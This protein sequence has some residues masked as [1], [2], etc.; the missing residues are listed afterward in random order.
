MRI[1]K[2]KMQIYNDSKGLYVDSLREV[3]TRRLRQRIDHLGANQKEMA[4][5]L[6]TTPSTIQ[7]W[8]KGENWPSSEVICQLADLLNVTP[9]WL[10]GGTLESLTQENVV[11][12]Q[13]LQ[14][15][16]DWPR[17]QPWDVLISTA[18]ALAEFKESKSED[19]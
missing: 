2:R 6:H 13:V 14:M 15:L 10:L 16:V 12:K 18:E 17:N 8:L 3:F 4:K 19:S 9:Q 7:R 11:P 5:S 1:G